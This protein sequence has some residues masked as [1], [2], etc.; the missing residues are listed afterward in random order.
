MQACFS[1]L[2]LKRPGLH[3]LVLW[4]PALIHPTLYDALKEPI[5][6]ISKV[7]GFLRRRGINAKAESLPAVT[8]PLKR[9]EY[10]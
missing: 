3:C 1:G 2:G 8:F 5:L 6:L 7:A 9:L 4:D 10:Q